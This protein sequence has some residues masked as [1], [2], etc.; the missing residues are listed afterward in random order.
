MGSGNLLCAVLAFKILPLVRRENFE[1]EISVLL[2]SDLLALVLIRR[3]SHIYLFILLVADETPL[4]FKIQKKNLP[5]HPVRSHRD[6]CKPFKR[7]FR[8]LNKDNFGFLRVL[9]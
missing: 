3:L 9:A 7:P 5:K 6:N 4:A 1:K 8:F 2:A